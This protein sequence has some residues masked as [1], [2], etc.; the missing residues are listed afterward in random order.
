MIPYFGYGMGRQIIQQVIRAFVGTFC[1]GSL[2][3]SDGAESRKD[4]VIYGACIVEARAQHLLDAKFPF[5]I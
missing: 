4:G 2:F 5:L 1:R 3:T